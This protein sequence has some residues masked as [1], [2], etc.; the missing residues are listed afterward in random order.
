M[1]CT[2]AHSD[3]VVFGKCGE[4]VGGSVFIRMYG[5]VHVGLQEEV[6]VPHAVQI[7]QKQ[8]NIQLFLLDGCVGFRQSGKELHVG[9]LCVKV[10]WP[11]KSLN[12]RAQF[13]YMHS[14]IF[15]VVEDFW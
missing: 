8:A 9:G 11:V 7:W 13:V 1:T 2:I 12:R 4:N 6:P 14:R 15:T 10:G 3:E 5:G